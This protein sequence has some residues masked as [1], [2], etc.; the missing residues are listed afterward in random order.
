[1]LDASGLH[2]GLNNQ[3]QDVRGLGG[4]LTIAWAPSS[5]SLALRPRLLSFS[6]NQNLNT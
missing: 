4:I 3:S 2:V 1:M 5:G 6:P